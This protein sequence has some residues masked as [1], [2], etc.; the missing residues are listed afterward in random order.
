MSS[1][2]GGVGNT[3]TSASLQ[4][5]NQATDRV[6]LGLGWGKSKNDDGTGNA[7]Q[8]NQNVTGGV[9]YQL[10]KSLT[11]VGEIGQTQSKAFNGNSARQDSVSV[12]GIFFC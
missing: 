2:S 11:L 7:L 9:Y 1:G 6:K 12:G 4:A 8:S 3:T 5:T 10:T